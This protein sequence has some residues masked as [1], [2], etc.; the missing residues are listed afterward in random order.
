MD[1]VTALVGGLIIGV[2]ATILLAFNG[3]I[4]GISGILWGAISQADKAWRLAFIVGLPIG[5][6]LL[7]KVA[8]TPIPEPQ[9]SPWLVIIAGLI[10]GIGVKIGSGCTSGHGVCGIGRLSIRSIAATLTFIATG[11]ITVAITGGLS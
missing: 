2:S 5:A 6:W 4:A 7:H 11:V 8:G 3:R 9:G 1:Y 10:V